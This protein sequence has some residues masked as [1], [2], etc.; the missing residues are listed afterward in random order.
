MSHKIITSHKF[1][2]ITLKIIISTSRFLIF[3]RVKA[4]VL[5]QRM[6]FSPRAS[7][8]AHQAGRF[9]YPSLVVVVIVTK[10]FSGGAM[11]VE[12]QLEW[13]SCKAIQRGRFQGT[14]Q[15]HHLQYIYIYDASYRPSPWVAGASFS[16][17]DCHQ[18]PRL[19][20]FSRRRPAGE[21]F[22]KNFRK[23][24]HCRPKAF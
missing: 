9:L 23:I 11:R 8:S 17:E 22:L 14:I 12:K 16:G 13:W 4:N 18:D 1:N 19:R 15:K 10:W 24:L 5:W 6:Q 21:F 3:Y 7:A 20:W 2:I